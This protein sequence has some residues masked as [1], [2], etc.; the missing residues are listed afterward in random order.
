M[1]PLLLLA[2]VGCTSASAD[3]HDV[4]DRSRIEI[5]PFDV[6]PF[7]DVSIDDPFGH[8][9]VEGHDDASVVVETRKEAADAATVDRLRVT[10]LPSH[11]G[12]LAIS[13]SVDG[14]PPVRADATRIDLVVHV[15]RNVRI[16]ASVADRLEVVGLDV[17]ANLTPRRPHAPCVACQP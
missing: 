4:V 3:P 5:H 14:G 1:Y 9:R 2:L 12:A 17:C 8:V 13:T 16:T 10:L 11:G 15:P 6:A 7:A